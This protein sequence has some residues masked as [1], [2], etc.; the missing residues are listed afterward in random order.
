MLKILFKKRQL[1]CGFYTFQLS[2]VNEIEEL[3]SQITQIYAALYTDLEQFYY[4]LY[5][6]FA[7]LFRQANMTNERRQS[8]PVEDTA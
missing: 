6:S 8:G 2:D 1:V 3:F 7:H 5:T 4:L